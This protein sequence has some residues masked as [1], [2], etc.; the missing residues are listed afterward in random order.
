MLHNGLIRRLVD[1]MRPPDV[2]FLGDDGQA[3]KQPRR[4]FLRSVQ[5]R[6]SRRRKL[7]SLFIDN[8]R[9]TNVIPIDQ[10]KH[11]SNSFGNIH[12]CVN[13]YVEMLY[14][15]RAT[16]RVKNNAMT[17]IMQLLR[18]DVK[19]IGPKGIVKCQH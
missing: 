5:Q 6:S 7:S 14:T 11:F 9:L 12:T 16:A 2:G 1:L 19:G 13:L 10:I 15:N 3:R 18:F 8:I 4:D 17:V